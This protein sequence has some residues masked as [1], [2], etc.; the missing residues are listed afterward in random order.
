MIANTFHEMPHCIGYLDGSEIKLAERPCCD[1]DSYYSRKQNFSIKIQAVCDS[2]LKIRHIF[3]GFPGSV[4]DSRI[5]S[6]SSLFLN[7]SVYFH[8][9]EWIAGDSAY[10]LSTTVIT[11]FR[12]NSPEPAS[13]KNGFNR[14]HS[15]YRV[16]IEHCFGILK[17]RFGSLKELRMRLIDE[18]SSKFAIKWI[19][20]CCILHNFVIDCNDDMFDFH[21]ELNA[22]QND[23]EAEENFPN[24]NPAEN[25]AGE[26]KRKTLHNLMVNS[27]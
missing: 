7:P 23:D 24:E 20:T 25:I 12:K 22:E 27:Q 19:T 18:E 11:P 14:L 5:F 26:L 1:P 2:Q 17:E 4:H 9:E 15:M 8:G 10:K 13:M 6:N 16:R 3:V 21:F